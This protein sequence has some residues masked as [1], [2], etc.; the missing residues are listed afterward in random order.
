[1]HRCAAGIEDGYVDGCLTLYKNGGARRRVSTAGLQGRWCSKG[2]EA[3][4]EDDDVSRSVVPSLK[5]A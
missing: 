5:C 2:G 1:M 3:P 4:A